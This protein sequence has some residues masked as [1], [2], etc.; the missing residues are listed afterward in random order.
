MKKKKLGKTQTIIQ[1]VIKKQPTI[2]EFYSFGNTNK[3]SVSKCLINE[4]IWS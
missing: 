4:N 3:L 1:Y 2:V